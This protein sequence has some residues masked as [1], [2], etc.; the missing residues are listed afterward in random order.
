[1][2]Q[3]IH[4]SAPSRAPRCTLRTRSPGGQAAA[5][6][7]PFGP[8]DLAWCFGYVAISL[9]AI[10]AAVVI[11]CGETGSAEI[12]MV[13]S[14]VR[15]APMAQDTCSTNADPKSRAVKQAC[16]NTLEHTTDAAGAC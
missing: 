5:A 1:M 16:A 7:V 10:A 14:V 6:T 11:A 4:S 3:G 9:L 13:S 8:A 2:T 12:R 15:A